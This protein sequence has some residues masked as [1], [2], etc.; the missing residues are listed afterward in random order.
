MANR[1][2]ATLAKTIE[3]ERRS[4]K[5]KIADLELQQKPLREKIAELQKQNDAFLS[6]YVRKSEQ[7]RVERDKSLVQKIFG[8]NSGANEE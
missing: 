7:L 8:G 6:M 2:N 5:A 3:D 1:K 4:A